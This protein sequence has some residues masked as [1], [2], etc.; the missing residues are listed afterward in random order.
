MCN[1]IQLVDLKGI[2]TVKLPV[3]CT[4]VWFMDETICVTGLGEAGVCNGHN[5]LGYI[6]FFI[7]S[8]SLPLDHS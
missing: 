7:L 1:I 3:Q 5:G 4:R 6:A 8:L 2:P